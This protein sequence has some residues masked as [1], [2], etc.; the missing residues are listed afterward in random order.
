MKVLVCG[1]RAFNDTLFLGAILELLHVKR[2]ITSVVEGGAFGADRLARM[3]A[4]GH[5]ISVQTFNADWILYGR[6]AGPVRNRKMHRE[7]RPDLVV[8]FQGGSGT[9][10]MVSVAQAAGTPVLKTWDLASV[11]KFLEP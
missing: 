7:A 1:G 9:A 5:N 8:A 11:A 10:D 4:I 2:P 3:W 6:R